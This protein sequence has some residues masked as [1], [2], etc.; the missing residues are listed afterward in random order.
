LILTD[1]EIKISIVNKSIEISP[2]PTDDAYAS[3]SVD[4]TLDRTIRCYKPQTGGVSIT[5]DPANPAYRF[6]EANAQLTH[7]LQIADGGY[8]LD[9]GKLILAWTQEEVNLNSISRIAARVEG[10]SSLARIG[11]GIHITSPPIHDGF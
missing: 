9:P 11:L 4:L 7:E 1:R 10:K 5:I 6:A 3:T 2:Q 8:D